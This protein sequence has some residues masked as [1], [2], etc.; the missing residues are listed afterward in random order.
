MWTNNGE[1]LHMGSS[2]R[3]ATAAISQAASA[4]QLLA[5]AQQYFHSYHDDQESAMHGGFTLLP[6]LHKH[7]FLALAQLKG[8]GR[9][10]QHV[11]QKASQVG[12]G[13]FLLRCKN[14]S[15]SIKWRKLKRACQNPASF[16]CSPNKTCR[17][18][19]EKF[20]ITYFRSS[21]KGRNHP[22]S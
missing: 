12:P 10:A 7:G 20:R 2:R 8:Y 19:N 13:D 14:L 17:V 22:L 16:L 15:G 3:C 9:Y 1:E 21:P 18:S 6:F 11:G 5:C 4:Y